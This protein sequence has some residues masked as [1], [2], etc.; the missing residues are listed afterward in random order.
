MLVLGGREKRGG[1]A[2]Y[3]DVQRPH[4]H[5][6][7]CARETRRVAS[8]PLLSDAPPTGQHETPQEY[9]DGELQHLR[10]LNCGPS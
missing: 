4:L 10:H 5:G 2:E 1:H 9:E 6:F 8:G 3:P 7:G